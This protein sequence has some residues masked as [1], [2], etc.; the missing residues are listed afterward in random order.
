MRDLLTHFLVR[1]ARSVYPAGKCVNSTEPHDAN[2]VKRQGG[3]RLAAEELAP[4]CRIEAL[5]HGLDRT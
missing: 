4:G 1:D 5:V 3:D 2:A